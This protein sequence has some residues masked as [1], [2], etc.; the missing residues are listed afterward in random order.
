MH[1]AQCSPA[2]HARHELPTHLNAPS[3]RGFQGF[4]LQSPSNAQ[5]DR[6]SCATVLVIEGGYTIPN[7]ERVRVQLTV[8]LT[9]T[10]APEAPGPDSV[11]PSLEQK[12]IEHPGIE[13]KVFGPFVNGLDV[14]QQGQSRHNR[15]ATFCAG[16]LHN[17]DYNLVKCQALV[18]APTRELAQQIEKV[19]RALDKGQQVKH[20][21]SS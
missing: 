19:M 8:E 14:I 3:I 4:F 21:L 20:R 9:P 12:I 6:K 2:V 18:L 10:T 5:K 17:L 13:E 7:M 15:T 16:I 11:L 1:A